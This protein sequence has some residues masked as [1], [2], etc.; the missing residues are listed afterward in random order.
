MSQI[1]SIGEGNS[2]KSVEDNI[3]QS[4]KPVAGV[5]QGAKS[6]KQGGITP[7]RAV[8][9]TGVTSDEFASNLPEWDLVPPLVAVRRIRKR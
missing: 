9:D 2:I 8:R 6:G 7:V 5:A 1:K 4:I 3:S